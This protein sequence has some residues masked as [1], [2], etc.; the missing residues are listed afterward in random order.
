M[1]R[2]KI[3][4]VA[5]G[6]RRRS[7]DSELRL[8]GESSKCMSTSMYCTRV[9]MRSL[10]ALALGS[11][12]LDSQIACRSSNSNSAKHMKKFGWLRGVA[13]AGGAAIF[14]ADFTDFVM[15]ASLETCLNG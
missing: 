4:L 9:R 10:V 8:R 7:M 6:P 2:E 3:V 14:L 15:L 5:P 11:G 12:I 1:R 13:F